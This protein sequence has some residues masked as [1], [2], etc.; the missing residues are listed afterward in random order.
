M[1]Q[2]SIQPLLPQH[3]DERCEK[4]HQEARIQ[5]TSSGDNL[6]G[7]ALL[8]R[9][10]GGGFVWHGGMV[11]SEENRTEERCCLFVGI[12]SKLGINIDDEG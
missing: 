5:E 6:V 12:G 11:E 9:Q 2:V 4:R 7:R 10:N 8:D 1:P 3:R